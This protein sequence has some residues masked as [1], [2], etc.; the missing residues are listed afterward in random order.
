MECIGSI[1]NVEKSKQIQWP[2]SSSEQ[3][4]E[5]VSEVGDILRIIGAENGAR[6]DLNE[7]PIVDVAAALRRQV[8]NHP[9]KSTLAVLFLLASFPLMK[10]WHPRRV[11]CFQVSSPTVR[12]AA[13]ALARLHAAA[14]FILFSALSD[15]FN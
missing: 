4:S 6:G 3:E 14:T 10:T 12:K 7:A 9:R 2:G 8:G 11:L 1:L 5:S 15:D 13:C